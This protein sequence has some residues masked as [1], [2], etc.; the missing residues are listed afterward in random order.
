MDKIAPCPN[1]GSKALYKSEEV[2]AGGGYAPNYLPGL[3]S[4]WIAERFNLVACKDCGLT[5]FSARPG[6]MAKL[7]GSKKWKQV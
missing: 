4:F 3:G 2:L 6:A 5:R 1:C 7:P